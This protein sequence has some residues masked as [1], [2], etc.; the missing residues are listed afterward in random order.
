M[1]N[2]VL[3]PLNILFTNN[4][5]ISNNQAEMYIICWKLFLYIGPNKYIYIYIYKKKQW[6]GFDSQE[7]HERPIP[8]IQ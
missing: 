7:I 8:W 1:K 6:H 2:N 5:I 3:V 4:S